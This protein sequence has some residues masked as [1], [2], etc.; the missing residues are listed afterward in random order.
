MVAG[1]LLIG[2]TY[3]LQLISALRVA[4]ITNHGIYK[5]LQEIYVNNRTYNRFS[6]FHFAQDFSSSSSRFQIPFGILNNLCWIPVGVGPL[7]LF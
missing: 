3:N 1:C 2:G 7:E 6:R 4:T 5:V